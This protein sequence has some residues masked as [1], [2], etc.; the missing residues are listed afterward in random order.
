MSN[1]FD[2]EKAWIGKLNNALANRVGQGVKARI[3]EGS[4]KLSKD[5]DNDDVVEWSIRAITKLD[6]LV[7]DERTRRDVLTACA[8][9]YPK[10]QLLEIKNEYA[11]TKDLKRVHLRLQDQFVTF[12]KNELKL[13]R[14]TTEEIIAKGWGLAGVLDGNTV[15]ATKIPKSEFLKEYM[16]ETDPVKKRW[17]YCHCPRVRNILKTSKQISTTYCYCGAGYYKGIWEE[18]LQKPVEVEVLNSLMKGDDVCKIAI[19]LPND[20]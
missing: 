8:C 16:N 11:Q 17:Y 3:L 20:S 13:D 4:E 15:Y 18:I 9:Q 6:T 7:E 1:I 12:L 2:F 14:E 19:H 10:D 5:S